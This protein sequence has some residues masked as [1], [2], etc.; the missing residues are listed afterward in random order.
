M[1]EDG[2]ED[3]EVKEQ[4]GKRM[5]ET[6]AALKTRLKEAKETEQVMGSP[7]VPDAGTL[8]DKGALHA[9]SNGKASPSLTGSNQVETTKPQSN[10]PV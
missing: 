6:L 7:E 5:D 3:D 1:A 4:Y 10:E 2:D 9:T 8:D